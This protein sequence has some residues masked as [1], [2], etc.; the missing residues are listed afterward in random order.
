MMPP[1]PDFK[2]SI[3]KKKVLDFS[4][5]VVR[6]LFA[7]VLGREISGLTAL[8]GR[9]VWGDLKSAKTSKYDQIT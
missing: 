3:F 7:K 8:R 9:K 6:K 2:T 4:K 5:N 1:P